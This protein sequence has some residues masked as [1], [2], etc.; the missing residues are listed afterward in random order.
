M[1]FL[2]IIYD[3]GV[4]VVVVD[5]VVVMYVGRIV[6]E[7]VV[8]DVFVCLMYFYI[9]GLMVVILVFGCMLCG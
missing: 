1:G 8:D 2:L 9:S 4:V 5:C 7:G 3:L 6:E